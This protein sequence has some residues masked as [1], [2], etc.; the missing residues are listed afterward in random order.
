MIITNLWPTDN[1][2]VAGQLKQF[3][4]ENWYDIMI[5]AETVK[6]QSRLR[7]DTRDGGCQWSNS[8]TEEP[9]TD[10]SVRFKLKDIGH[11]QGIV[12]WSSSKNDS[13][14]SVT[15]LTGTTYEQE[16]FDPKQDGNDCHYTISWNLKAI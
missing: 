3:G 14:V 6:L 10:C 16:P 4:M 11:L 1:K 5:P 8:N 15:N 9:L 12:S 2:I 7:T 13:S